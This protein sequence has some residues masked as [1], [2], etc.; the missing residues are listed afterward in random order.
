M[1]T[2]KVAVI[3]VTYNH[4]RYIADALEGFVRQKTSF[5]FRVFVGDDCSTDKTPEI[6]LSYAEKYPHVII[7]VLRKRNITAGRNWE[8][9][10]ARTSEEYL[11]FC[12]GDDYWTDPL[13]LQK[14]YDYMEAHPELR[15]CFHDALISV[16]TSDGKWFQSKDY[17]NTEDG[18]LLWPSGNK[19]FRK[20]KTYR[21]ENFVMFGFVHTSSM[22]I[23]WDRSI[24]FPEWFFGHGVG[25]YPM[26]ML[27]VNTGRFGYLDEIMSVHRR[28]D[29][30]SYSFTKREEYWR[31]SKPGW[32]TLDN[33][34]LRHFESLGPE[35]KTIV[36]ALELRRKDDL[37]KLIASSLSTDDPRTTWNL[38]LRFGE[39]IKECF[40]IGIPKEYGKGRF[41][42]LV[43][44]LRTIAPLPP[45]KS[46]VI[47]KLL[48][49]KNRACEE[50][51]LRMP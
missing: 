16:E 4:E 46:N 3:C 19:R 42:H 20:R 8:D 37:A 17:G 45:Y 41:D 2:S 26:W 32:I 47:A 34:L 28:T 21:I 11:A 33:C 25:D 31:K 48:R 5:P 36:K 7:P 38:M 35:A 39:E 49:R 22:F 27:Q 13:K 15:S 30:G 1:G 18:K 10:V 9:L 23:R 50:K 24:G 51:F 12:D 6:I 43:A 40:H 29:S 14:Q 44:A